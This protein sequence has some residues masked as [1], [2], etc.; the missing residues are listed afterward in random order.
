MI[1]PS[2]ILFNS[3]LS[4]QDY[5]NSTKKTQLGYINY[6]FSLIDPRNVLI[7][8]SLRILSSEFSFPSKHISY[9]IF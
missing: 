9:Y 1:I 2:Y 7:D 3:R 8:T 4:Y 5:I 6:Q